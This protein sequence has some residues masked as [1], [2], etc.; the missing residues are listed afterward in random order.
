[1]KYSTL[2][3]DIDNTLLDSAQSEYLAL[4]KILEPAGVSVDERLAEEYRKINRAYWARF[5]S[6]LIDRKTVFKGR[7]KE[8]FDLYSLNLDPEK[9]SVLFLEA[10]A[11]S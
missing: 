11:D 4:K 6:G 7:I 2:L 5:N 3:F 9:Y 1:M 10:F 8:L